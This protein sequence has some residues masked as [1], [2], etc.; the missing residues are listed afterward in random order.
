[1]LGGGSRCPPRRSRRVAAPRG[2]RT[3]AAA[4][5]PGA[6]RVGQ[7]RVL[8]RRIAWQAATE[9]IEPAHSLALTFTRKA[10]GELRARSAPARHPR[11]PDRGHVPR[12]RARAAPRAARAPFHADARA[13]RPQGP[14][15]RTARRR[16]PRPGPA[17][18]GAR[19]RGRDRVGPGAARRPGGLRGGRGAR[20]AVAE[21]AAR[22]RRRHLP[23]LPG[24]EAPAR[25]H[26]L[27]RPDP[28]HRARARDRRRV[29]GHPTLAV[30][31]LLRRRVPGRQPR[32]AAAAPGLARRAR[33]AVRRRRPRPGDLLVRRRRPA[34]PH[35][36]RPSTSTAAPSSDSRSTTGRRPRSST[37]PVPCSPARAGRR[38]GRRP[39]GSA[40]HGHHLRRRRRRG[41]RRRAAA[42]GGARRAPLVGSR[43][44]L[45]RQRAV[46]AVR[47]GAASR[48]R[49]RSGCAA[50]ARS[51]TGPR[52]AARS[53][54]SRRTRPRHPA[55][56]SPSTSPTSSSTPPRPPT[57]SARTGRRS[58]ASATSTSRS[59]PDAGTVA[60]F[61][62][63]LRT[64]LRGQDDGGVADDAVELLTFHRAK[65]LEWDTVFVTGLERGLVPISHAQGDAEALDEERRL[66]YV[67]LSR[68]ERA[69]HVSWASERDRG[70][71]RASTRTCEPLSRGVRA[72]DRG[73]GARGHRPR[74]Q[75]ARSPRGTRAAQRR[76]RRRAH[77][78]RPARLRRPRRVASRRVTRRRGPGVRRVRQQGAPRGRAAAG[79]ASAGELLAVS[80]RRAHEAR[81]LRRRGARDR[82]PPRSVA[83]RP[84]RTS[85]TPPGATETPRG[86]GVPSP[87]V[88]HFDES[89]ERIAQLCFDY[90]IERLRMDPAPLDQPRSL[91]E[92]TAAVG[93]TIDAARSRPRDGA[94]LVPRHA[95]ARRASP[96]TAPPSS[97]S[98]RARR[99]RRASCST[100]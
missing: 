83:H 74:D 73:Q 38:A 65:G 7:D 48:R 99:R 100:S 85:F 37:P 14:R 98:C 19:G 86:P 64:T 69:L 87:V 3:R 53:P 27:R 75:P 41:A 90:A 55:G 1:M 54:S 71:S 21:A 96:P 2:H 84:E 36:L 34:V 28:A 80:G 16:S 67:A 26:R 45:P 35:R 49:S 63:F 78:R 95:R 61:L 91:A 81:A 8:T 89:T 70:G 43:G 46:G 79:P 97:R 88:H 77:A 40:A 44:P 18:R 5:D 76:G 12:R 24:R 57:T 59:P 17:A 52:C 93:P 32:A 94:R 72:R 92:L 51:W 23:P 31:T 22:A 13:A 20:R 47:G 58:S 82:R 66:L 25:R 15:A 68:A 60:E 29:R 10:A 39:A 56:T 30:P 11:R 9:A 62:E 33:R 4:R 6:R 50:T 42:P